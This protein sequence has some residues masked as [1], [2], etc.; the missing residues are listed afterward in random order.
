D[1]YLE[2][3]LLITRICQYAV[4]KCLLFYLLYELHSHILRNVLKQVRE[5]VTVTDTESR[6]KE[7]SH[8]CVKAN[9]LL[10]N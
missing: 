6:L 4:S 3:A 7:V 8:A 10:L 2:Q 5:K 9:E 1:E